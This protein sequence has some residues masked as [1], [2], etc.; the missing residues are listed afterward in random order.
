METRAYISADDLEIINNALGR[1][2][3]IRIVCV[4]GGVKIQAQKVRTLRKK[5]PSG[6]GKE[7]RNNAD[8][9]F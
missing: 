5:A 4:P 1:G 6:N 9:Q 7:T 2:E 8:V 3:D